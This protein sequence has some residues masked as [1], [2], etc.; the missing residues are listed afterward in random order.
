MLYGPD[1]VGV[2][3]REI[4]LLSERCLRLGRKD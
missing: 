2:L 1:A 3:F 4:E